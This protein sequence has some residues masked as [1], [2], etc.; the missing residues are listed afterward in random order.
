MV[1][2]GHTRRH[3]RLSHAARAKRFAPTASF[4]PLLAELLTRSRM[5]GAHFYRGKGDRGLQGV[6]ARVC[7]GMYGPCFFCQN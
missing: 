3:S 7:V 1:R 6:V 4:R 5:A 2:M